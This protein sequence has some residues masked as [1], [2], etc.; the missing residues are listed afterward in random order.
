MVITVGTM[1]TKAVAWVLAV[2]WWAREKA[3]SGAAN[4][5]VEA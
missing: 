3:S 1:R 5:R 4:Q 2:T